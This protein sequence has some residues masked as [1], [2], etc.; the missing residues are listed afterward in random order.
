MSQGAREQQSTAE[1]SAG[2]D[3]QLNGLLA[4]SFPNVRMPLVETNEDGEVLVD[5]SVCYNMDCQICEP[6]HDC[7]ALLRTLER[8][9]TDSEGPFGF[10]FRRGAP[11]ESHSSSVDGGDSTSSGDDEGGEPA[12]L[13]EEGRKGKKKGKGRFKVKGARRSS[14][15]KKLR[16]HLS[17]LFPRKSTPAF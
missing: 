7:Q 13:P 9:L 8:V 11:E 6:T 5:S 12:N 16:T 4:E 14:G 17:Q 3:P 2:S 10:P 1:P 15:W